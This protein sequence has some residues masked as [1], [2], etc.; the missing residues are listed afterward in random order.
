MIKISHRGNISGRETEKENHPHYIQIALDSGYDVEVDVWFENSVLYLGHDE[1]M[2]PISLE[3][4]IARCGRLWIHCKDLSSIIYFNGLDN[5]KLN[6]FWHEEDTVTLTS[7]GFI[8]A[9]P[10]E[11][12]PKN[13]IGVMPEVFNSDVSNCIGV[14]SDN[15]KKYK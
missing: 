12:Y 1:P 11:K 15:I 9:Y 2:Y 5:K 14:C 6:Y 10:T 8:W 13:S 3:W 7:H 4:F